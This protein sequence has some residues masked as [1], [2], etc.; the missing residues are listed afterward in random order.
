MDVWRSKHPAAT[1]PVIN[2]PTDLPPDLSTTLGILIKRRVS[3]L[4]VVVDRSLARRTAPPH[5]P[6]EPRPQGLR[7]RL[8]LGALPRPRL[9]R[10]YDGRCRGGP[11]IRTRLLSR[12]HGLALGQQ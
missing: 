12:H 7:V 10:G 11:A 8:R 3:D 6:L 2:R 9:L 4:L 5:R 1:A